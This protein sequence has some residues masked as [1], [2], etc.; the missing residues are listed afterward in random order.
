MRWEGGHRVGWPVQAV[1]DGDAPSVPTGPGTDEMSSAF[2]ARHRGQ[3]LVEAGRAPGPP[4]RLDQAIVG[5]F[6]YPGF[7][8]WH[9]GVD[10]G[11]DIIATVGGPDGDTV[12]MIIDGEGAE[13][14]V[15]DEKDG[16]DLVVLIGRKFEAG[17]VRS[18]AAQN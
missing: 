14:G 15:G 4:L 12:R 16:A 1:P 10:G 17:R 2:R 3:R 6:T 18:R 5:A 9:I 8:T 7:E 13:A 11:T